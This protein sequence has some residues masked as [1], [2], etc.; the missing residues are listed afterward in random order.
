MHVGR[1]I[2]MYD[3]DPPEISPAGRYVQDAKLLL[4]PRFSRGVS[5]G[6]GCSNSQMGADQ[7]PVMLGVAVPV[8]AF[9]AKIW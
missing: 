4:V 7:P 2:R 9:A 3:A 6:H 8:S 1:S 5:S